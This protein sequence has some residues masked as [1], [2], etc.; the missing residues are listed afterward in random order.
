LQ[1]ATD[2]AVADLRRAAEPLA[3]ADASWRVAYSEVLEAYDRVVYI[4]PAVPPAVLSSDTILS[5]YHRAVNTLLDLL[6]EP[7][8]G[9]GRTALSD[10]VLRYVQFARVQ[11]LSSRIRAELYAAARAGRYGSE[12]QIVLADLR[13]QQLTALGAFRVAATGEQIGRYDRMSVDPAFA[14]GAELEERSL[15]TGGAVPEVLPASQWWSA[16]EER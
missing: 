14:A 15:P 9:Q 13:A 3:D 5:N 7:D 4:R 16:S 11:E 10:A 2:R 12:D 6:A 8:P 1:A